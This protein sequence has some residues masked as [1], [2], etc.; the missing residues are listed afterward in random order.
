MT[1]YRVFNLAEA[2]LKPLPLRVVE[3]A[4]PKNDVVPLLRFAVQA[5]PEPDKSRIAV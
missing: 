1:E 4:A 3:M 2:E 5:D